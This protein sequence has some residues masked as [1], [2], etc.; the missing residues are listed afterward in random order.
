MSATRDEF[1]ELATELMDEFDIGQDSGEMVTANNYSKLGPGLPPSISD[2]IT[3]RMI[4]SSFTAKEVENLDKVQMSDVKYKVSVDES[5]SFNFN[6]AT[7]LVSNGV[8]YQV[9]EFIPSPKDIMVTMA[10]RS[11]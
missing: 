7:E 11:V 4:R 8:K 3:I 1:S 2:T 6:T 9:V 10:A 5:M